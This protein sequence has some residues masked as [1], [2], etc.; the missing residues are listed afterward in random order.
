MDFLSNGLFWIFFALTGVFM[1]LFESGYS[2]KGIL[3]T[4][5]C[6]LFMTIGGLVLTV[7]LILSFVFIWWQGGLAILVSDFI[8][9]I[10]AFIIGN[11]LRNILLR[12]FIG[13]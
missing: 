2:G 7:V 9:M 1:F 5:L 8:W 13:H 6:Q 12:R 11:V 3:N 4:S 10:I